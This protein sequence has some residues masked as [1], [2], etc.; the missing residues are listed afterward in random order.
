MK[1]LLVVILLILGGFQII[2]A[3]QDEDTACDVETIK[4]D[5]LTALEAAGN[6]EDLTRVQETLSS[7]L[8]TCTTGGEV[9]LSRTSP[10]PFGEGYIFEDGIV[11]IVSINENWSDDFHAPPDGSRFLEVMLS[12]ECQL[13]DI[14]QE[15]RGVNIQTGASYVTEGG[16]ILD[17]EFWNGGIGA[18]QAYSGAILEGNVIFLLSETESG[19]LV[20]L[21]IKS[22]DVF[23]SLLQ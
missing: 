12:W 15:C 4:A 1:H 14:N 6:V 20:R 7:A 17:M 13:E 18:V 8:V 10:I 23:F 19:G 21:S 2:F 11:K 9:G 16:N 22:Q 5:A 3:Q